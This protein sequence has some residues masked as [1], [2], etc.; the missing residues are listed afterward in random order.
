MPIRALVVDDS[1]TMRALVSHALSRDPAIEVVGTAEDPFRAREMIKALNPDV[2]TL[3]VEMP[4]MDGL[5]FLAKI[6]E[7][8]PMPVVMV[9]SL[10]EKGAAATMDAFEL[11]AF[12]CYA[13]PKGR[14]P[15]TSEHGEPTLAD[16]VKAAAGSRRGSARSARTAAPATSGYRARPDTL[17]AVGAST[18]G[19]EALIELLSGFPANCPPTV[20]VQH[21]PPGFTATFAAR[22]DRMSAPKVQ[23]ARSGAPLQHGNVYLAPGGENH[24]ELVGQSELRC[25]LVPG[26]KMSGHRPSVDRLFSSVAKVAG[27]RAVGA[28]LTGMGQ[29]GA[30]GLKAMR[31]AGSF[32]VGQDRESS[33]VYGMPAVAHSVGAVEVQLPLA[34]IAARLLKECQA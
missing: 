27:G 17:I 6:M 13:K 15:E 28:I 33:V 12:D 3:D 30:Q 18:G 5:S 8:R 9:S 19:V 32:T 4:G 7:L 20:I 10:T 22:L 2:L 31:D 23:E 34:R 14:F 24:L 1:P 25:R 16:I 26:D 29:D 21:M 11:G